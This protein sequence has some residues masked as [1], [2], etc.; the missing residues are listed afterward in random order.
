MQ[1][2]NLFGD[3]SSPASPAPQITEISLKDISSAIDL[4]EFRRQQREE[5]HRHKLTKENAIDDNT[6]LPE[7]LIKPSDQLDSHEN[8]VYEPEAET[9]SSSRDISPGESLISRGLLECHDSSICDRPSEANP[10]YASPIIDIPPP[11]SYD[12][13]EETIEP[14]TESQHDSAFGN[15]TGDTETYT[16]LDKPIKPLPNGNLFADSYRPLRSDDTVTSKRCLLNERTD[17][18]DFSQGENTR[19]SSLPINKGDSRHSFTGPRKKRKSFYERT[20]SRPDRG[21]YSFN[22]D[23]FT[24]EELLCMWKSKE[25]EL[26]TRLKEAV[27]DKEKL[28]HKLAGRHYSTPV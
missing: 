14:E 11:P 23:Q 15:A 2:N 16:A 26:N 27:R 19:R 5:M 1:D 3:E 24:K 6:D 25:L 22:I 18:T 20:G 10:F 28:E 12:M 7:W 9:A 4:N 21:D 17:R 8:A 13:I